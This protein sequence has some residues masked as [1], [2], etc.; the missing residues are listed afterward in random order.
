MIRRYEAADQQNLLHFADN[1]LRTVQL[2]DSKRTKVTGATAHKQV[3]TRR[4]QVVDDDDDDDDDDDAKHVSTQGNSDVRPD[5]R[6]AAAAALKKKRRAH[7]S[8]ANEPLNSDRRRNRLHTSSSFAASADLSKLSVRS[9]E[10]HASV[11]ASH[12]NDEQHLLAVEQVFFVFFFFVET[13]SMCF[14]L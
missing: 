9:D 1:E 3:T 11:D 14:F 7:F 4:E 10:A 2:D 8:A 5:S 12:V 6:R 13:C